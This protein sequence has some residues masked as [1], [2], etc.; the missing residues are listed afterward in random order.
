MKILFCGGGTAGH[1]S[2]AIAIAEIMKGAYPGAEI[3]FVGRAGGDENRAITRAG[4]KLYTVEVE[5]LCRRLSPALLKSIK[6]A[7]SA[8]AE[9]KKILRE[10]SPDIV[11]GTGGYVSWPVIRAASGMKIKTALHESNAEAGLVTRLLATKCDVVLLNLADAKR[12]LPK[13]ARTEVVGNPV[14]PSFSGKT[15]DDA[16]AALGIP[17]RDILVVSF[18]GSG[19]SEKMNDA[20]VE[21]MRSYTSRTPRLRHIHAT[22]RKY[23]PKLKEREPRLAYGYGG[24]R[25]VPYIENAPEMLLAADISIT[26][27]GAM[28]LAELSAAGTAA[29]LIPSPNVTANHQYKNALAYK[30]HGG[31]ILIPEEE[32]SAQSLRDVLCNLVRDG[33]LRNKMQ[34]DIKALRDGKVEEKI[35][36][37]LTELM[38]QTRG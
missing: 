28:T 26:R 2:P 25:I 32:L 27:S 16:K 3:A 23:F 4:Y 6:K 10:F 18:G 24:A 15:K 7:F 1:V 31:A 37:I 11:I 17:K 13:R 22:G 9:A 30:E 33:A 29:I 19:G 12:H 38:Q 34:A 8:T 35:L 5:G 21:L 20:I 36:A 14:H